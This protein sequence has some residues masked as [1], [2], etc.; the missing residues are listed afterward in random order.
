MEVRV[1]TRVRSTAGRDK[2]VDFIVIAV[3]GE[4]LSLADGDLRKVDRPKRKKL[5]HVQA[6][7]DISEFIAD[8]LAVTGK[9]T[10]AEVRKALAEINS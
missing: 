4:Y 2:G 8:K 5:K 9:V 10:N 3:E 1:G 7:A 6:S